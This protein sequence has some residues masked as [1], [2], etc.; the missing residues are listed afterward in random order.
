MG[1][2]S[3][4]NAKTAID[5]LKKECPQATNIVEPVQLDLTSDESIQKAYER[6][7]ADHG[8]LDVL[9]NNAGTY[10]ERGIRQR[11]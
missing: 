7:Q 3:L 6:V 2:R 4:D 1:S 11:Y 5:T 8:R 9:V 10:A